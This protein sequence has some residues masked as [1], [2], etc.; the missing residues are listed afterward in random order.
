MRRYFTPSQ[1]LRALQSTAADI[2]DTWTVPKQ[3]YQTT[4]GGT[5]YSVPNKSLMIQVSTP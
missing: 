5:Q 3:P 1:P 4:G 2:L